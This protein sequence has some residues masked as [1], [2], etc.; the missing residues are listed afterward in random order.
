MLRENEARNNNL[1]NNNDELVDERRG[2]IQRLEQLEKET[3][4]NQ[5][6]YGESQSQIKERDQQLEELRSRITVIAE[7]FEKKPIK[8][9][10][11]FEVLCD[12][13]HDKAKR[14]F[15][16]Y[17]NSIKDKKGNSELQRQISKLENEVKNLQ[18][19]PNMLQK[20]VVPTAMTLLN[21]Q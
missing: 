15:N 13:V 5:T 16:K 3:S 8:Q 7:L 1:K 21:R 12:F 10:Y 2:L 17:E 18:E 4:D 11:S 6:Q 14:L 20:I 9:R 19:Y